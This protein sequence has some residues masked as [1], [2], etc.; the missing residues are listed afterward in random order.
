MMEVT[1]GRRDGESIHSN[2]VALKSSPSSSYRLQKPIMEILYG[3]KTGVYAFGYN[4][5]ESEPIWMKRETL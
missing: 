2:A 1:A 3:T 4:S 5:A